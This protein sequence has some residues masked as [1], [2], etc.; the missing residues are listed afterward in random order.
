[1]N[2]HLMMEG[3]FVEKFIS[4][5]NDY[6]PIGEHY[7]Y[8][9]N[10]VENCEH[11]TSVKSDNVEYTSNLF[12]SVR[13][14]RMSSKD[15][16]F[17]HGF[18]LNH[19]VQYGTFAAS[20]LSRNQLV[21]IIY[22]ADLYNNRY[23]LQDNFV[24]PGVWLQE[25]KK[26]KLIKKIG[27]FMTFA[28]PDYDL[29]Y[30]WFG[31][32]G[33]QFDI[34]YPSNANFEQLYAIRNV[35]KNN[36]KTV[37]ILLG[38][39]ATSTNRHEEALEWLAKYKKEDIEIICPL[40]YGDMIYGNYIADIGRDIFGEKFI[41]ITEYMNIDE[42]TELLN[43]VDIAVYNNNRQQATGNIEIL[44]YLG[45]KIYVRSDIATWGHYVDRDGCRF[46]D[47]TLIPSLN[48][49]EFC[50]M[51]REDIDYNEQYF[52]KIWDNNYLKKLWDE[53]IQ[54]GN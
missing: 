52:L 46:F 32:D 24:H 9:Y 3:K 54:Y 29:M 45:K 10:N 15:K 38:N 31:A 17:I 11:P 20:Q 21:L 16:M 5:V 14:D 40:S 41:P 19:F 43:S 35:D 2:I 47:T 48:F 12:E 50:V 39:S 6:Y 7:F 49:E 26:K 37:R 28:S 23:I 33:K 18:F 30:K 1:M 42:Y 25:Y 34:L 53:V 8:I 13:L 4:F 22:G 36:E 51:N 44:G 27:L